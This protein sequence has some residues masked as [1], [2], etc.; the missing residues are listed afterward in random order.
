MGGTSYIGAEQGMERRRKRE[1]TRQASKQSIVDGMGEGGTAVECFSAPLMKVRL[2]P[3][4]EY[5][6]RLR[7]GICSN[8]E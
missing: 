7:S 2:K 6:W 3:T 5:V 4:L 8:G 1:S